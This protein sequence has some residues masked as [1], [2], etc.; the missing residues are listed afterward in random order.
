MKDLKTPELTVQK[1]KEV[2]QLLTAIN[3]LIKTK[4]LR[5]EGFEKLQHI[6]ADN[7]SVKNQVYYY[8]IKGKYYVLEFKESQSKELELLELANDCYSDMVTIAYYNNFS[9]K[10]SKNHF[11]RAYCKYL[12]ALHHS[13][14][15]V[16]IKLFQ[17][18]EQIAD[19]VLNFEPN[20]SSFLWLKLQLTT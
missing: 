15:E 16:K 14:N 7:L 3:E 20:N 18:A 11:A 5:K 10:D 2:H 19:R 13:S 6:D 1:E 8:Y 12:I 9:I 4:S 17:K